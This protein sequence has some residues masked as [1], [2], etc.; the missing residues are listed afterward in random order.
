MRIF[1]NSNGRSTK[2][3]S[4]VSESSSWLTWLQEAMLSLNETVR[5]AQQHGDD[6]T[7]A[8]TL[9]ALCHLLA[10]TPPSAA[11]P[12]VEPTPTQLPQA[13]HHSQLLRLLRRS[14]FFQSVHAPTLL[15]DIDHIVYVCLHPGSAVS[16][17]CCTPP[18]VN[19]SCSPAPLSSCKQPTTSSCCDSCAGGLFPHVNTFSWMLSYRSMRL[20]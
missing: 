10:S 9:A 1:R 11:Q 20:Q 7:L 15:E 6:V 12:L 4:G 16:S 5:I 17:P 2:G 14:A 19:P 3:Y 18:S 13:A 8:H